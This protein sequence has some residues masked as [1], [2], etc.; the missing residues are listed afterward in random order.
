MVYVAGNDGM[1]HAF[2]ADNGQERWAF[3]PSFVLPHLYKLASQG[4]ARL[5]EFLLDGSPTVG[6]VQTGGTWKTL[7]VGGAGRG[8]SGYY[9]LD[10]TTPGSPRALWEFKHSATCYAANNPST[11]YADCHLGRSIAEPRFTKLADGTWVVLVTSGYNNVS[12]NAGDGRGYLYVLDANTGRILRKIA[13]TEG[14][15]ATP[16]GLG[17]LTVYGPALGINNTAIY[18][19]A[20]DLLGNVWRFDINTGEAFRVATL[21]RG[22]V[23]QPITTRIVLGETGTPATLTLFVGTGR[24]L[25]LSDIADTQTQ[26]LYAIKD[27]SA[28]PLTDARSAL[29]GKV[30]AN[31]GN[32]RSITGTCSSS[33]RGWYVDLPDAGERMSV[34]PQFVG[35]VI[36]FATNVPS[37]QACLI[38]GGYSWLNYLDAETGCAI[39][40]ANQLVGK[41]FEEGQMPGLSI[42]V[43]TGDDPKTYR[44]GGEVEDIPTNTGAPAGRII[45]RRELVR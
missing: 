8:G 9:A 30:M 44:P 39:P 6:D 1:L 14:D 17:K 31:N 28:T 11:H 32:T 24:Y 36:V 29:E 13:T 18:V 35:N 25:G 19:Y 7:L 38:G 34:D 20:S 27:N 10:V 5:H 26:T 16:A 45:S 15:V 12:G 4:Y 43:T 41:K 2:D 37:D 3:I 22:S 42:V 40:A 33:G 21:M 23:R